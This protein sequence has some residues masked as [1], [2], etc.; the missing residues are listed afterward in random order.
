MA[1]PPKLRP[2]IDLLGLNN[3]PGDDIPYGTKNV[4]WGTAQIHAKIPEPDQPLM[5]ANE[6]IGAR[7]AIAIGLPGLPGEVAHYQNEKVWVTPQISEDSALTPPPMS[8]ELN[9]KFPYI[10]AGIKVFDIWVAN[11]DRHNENILFSPKIGAWLIDHEDILAANHGHDIDYSF[12]GWMDGTQFLG[13]VS[14]DNPH[15]KEWCHK[16]NN[17]HASIVPPI[18]NEA[19]ARNLLDA[20]YRD[21]YKSILLDRGQNIIKIVDIYAQRMKG[22]NK[23]PAT[24]LN[25]FDGGET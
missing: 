10:A 5:I 17:I 25:I 20:K 1:R 4:F 7:L 21:K 23:R 2:G 3:L 14:L 13:S 15:V 18:I 12:D 8:E 19:Y 24:Q 6:F 16:I 22:S 9:S 11:Q